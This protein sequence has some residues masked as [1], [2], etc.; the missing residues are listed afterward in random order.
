MSMTC[1]I[2]Y[3]DE[4]KVFNTEKPSEVKSLVGFKVGEE[5]MTDVLAKKHI[6]LANQVLGF[7]KFSLNT[8]SKSKIGDSTMQKF[9]TLP[10]GDTKFPRERR[11]QII[12]H[13]NAINEAEKKAFPYLSKNLISVKSVT[14]NNKE[15]KT[16]YIDIRPYAEALL[17]N[18]VYS[19][20]YIPPYKL[21]EIDDSFFDLYMKNALQNESFNKAQRTS[22]QFVEESSEAFFSILEKVKP[23]IATFLANPPDIRTTSSNKFEKKMRSLFSIINNPTEENKVVG[24]FRFIA[25]ATN[26]ASYGLKQL[27]HPEW[28]LLAR[29]DKIIKDSGGADKVSAQKQYE[30]SELAREINKI[31]DKLYLFNYLKDVSD[32]FNSEPDLRDN[33]FEIY[34]PFKLKYEVKL[35]LEN[36]GKGEFVDEIVDEIFSKS[37]ASTELFREKTKNLF[38]KIG[39]T[40][41]NEFFIQTRYKNKVRTKS[42]EKITESTPSEDIVDALTFQESIDKALSDMSK[43]VELTRDLALKSTA[44]ALYPGYLSGW[45]EEIFND[46]DKRIGGPDARERSFRMNFEQFKNSILVSEENPSTVN[47]WLAAGEQQDDSVIFATARTLFD[48]MRKQGF[49]SFVSSHK[50]MGAIKT[51]FG[52][53][54]VM[55]DSQR[56]QYNQEMTS[57]V[58][59]VPDNE[60]IVRMKKIDDDTF[61]EIKESGNVQHT[62]INRNK[63]VS[64]KIIEV[65]LSNGDWLVKVLDFGGESWVKAVKTKALVHEFKYRQKINSQSFTNTLDSFVNTLT[66]EWDK[67]N[68]EELSTEDRLINMRDYISQYNYTGVLTDSINKLLSDLSKG[69]E[70]NIDFTFNSQTLKRLLYESYND[71]HFELEDSTKIDAGIEYFFENLSTDGRPNRD[72][73]R[74]L[75][76]N[77]RNTDIYINKYNKKLN[78]AS[79]IDSGGKKGVLGTGDKVKKYLFRLTDGTYKLLS[80]RS[81][82]TYFVDENGKRVDDNL[83][84][85]FYYVSGDLLKQNSKTYSITETEAKHKEKFNSDSKYKQYYEF[86]KN[87]HDESNKK[88][89]VGRLEN[90]VLPQMQSADSKKLIDQLKSVSVKGTIKQSKAYLESFG[91]SQDTVILQDDDGNYVDENGNKLPEGFD[92]IKYVRNRQTLDGYDAKVLQPKFTTRIKDQSTLEQDLFVSFMAFEESVGTYQALFDIEPQMNFL[93]LLTSGNI[94]KKGDLK[95]FDSRLDTTIKRTNKFSGNQTK[96]AKRT[97]DNLMQMINHYV[98]GETKLQEEWLGKLNSQKIASAI[99]KLNAFQVLAWNWTAAFTNLEVGAFN[100]FSLG[101]GRRYGITQEAIT[102]GYNEYRKRIGDAVTSKYQATNLYERDHMT[103]LAIIFDAIKGN[104]VNPGEVFKKQETLTNKLHEIL[105]S[106]SAIPEHMN[107]LPLMIAYMKTYKINEKTG[108]TM[109]DAYLKGSKD[110]VK[111]NLVD[112]NGNDLSTDIVVDFMKKLDAI[113]SEAH[114]NYGKYQSSQL[115]RYSLGGLG[116]QF[117]R[118]IYSSVRARFEKGGYSK[119]MQEYVDRGYYRWYL[120]DMVGDLWNNIEGVY[121]AFGEEEIN[122]RPQLKS[123]GVSLKNTAVNLTVKQLAFIANSLSKGT[124][125]KNSPALEKWLYGDREDLDKI[126]LE[127]ELTRF[128]DETEEEF[129]ERIQKTYDNKKIA[130]HRAAFESTVVIMTMII[131][132]VLYAAQSDDDDDEIRNTSLKFFEIQARRFVSDL[133]LY[134]ININPFGPVDFVMRKVKDPFSV[135]RL[136]ENNLKVMTQ[137]AGFNFSAEGYNFKFNDVYEKSGE[138]YEKG[139]S[140]LWRLL[141]K[142]VLSPIG[143][144][145]R[146][147]NPEEL[148][149]VLSL[150]NKNSIYSSTGIEKE[151]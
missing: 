91:L 16:I 114:G 51:I 19:V 90:Y 147:L 148:D 4:I 40:V 129:K 138:G 106:S 137:I 83:L 17:H 25:E 49:E 12:D 87:K 1:N 93:K 121:H 112:E 73:K 120:K 32:L 42:G 108:Y 29:Y 13:I 151:K 96:V 30:L 101:V 98:Y 145:Q 84:D 100:N 66:G 3:I 36:N 64:G 74:W 144:T 125:A 43:V 39:L 58:F 80:Y 47:I 26:F 143:Q 23:K 38:N 111:I 77:A 118:W 107:Q 27:T 34:N 54:N 67:S 45:K 28:G 37:Y 128:P 134:T 18:S 146:L 105:F 72:A 11:E 6:A 60:R 21:E 132:G 140:K 116:M 102:D 92:P 15:Y 150:L 117:G 62:I 50:S 24:T 82:D 35:F 48:A 22:E 86:L 59:E 7:D 20:D 135:T 97:A 8:F 70:I 10:I 123:L 149:N 33:V 119:Q 115:E 61:G 130:L 71:Y 133:G 41:E 141:T 104:E 2:K 113:N 122:A 76:N 127:N 109:W 5:P 131:A 68:S 69:Y 110:Q 57:Y 14:I 124:L 81:S 53:S 142:T 95:L 63:D 88:L 136:L 94:A 46:A 85:S 99:K 55:N 79:I 56:L 65:E 139:D 89:S 44:A 75:Y 103:Q 126:I 9:L 52:D 78:I 31:K